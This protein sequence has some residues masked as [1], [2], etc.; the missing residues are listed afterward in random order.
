MGVDPVV[1]T[2]R[3]MTWPG[4]KPGRDVGLAQHAGDD[5]LRAVQVILRVLARDIRVALIQQDSGLAV[6]VREDAGR[7]LLPGL[8]VDQQA[9]DG[10]RPVIQTDAVFKEDRLTCAVDGRANRSGI[11]FAAEPPASSS[12]Y[13]VSRDVSHRAAQ[14][15]RKSGTVHRRACAPLTVLKCDV[16]CGAKNAA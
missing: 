3:P 1:S 12:T 4:E 11:D 8:D 13:G 7:D 14:T 16:L 15:H 6:R 10:V 5:G 2:P 9:P